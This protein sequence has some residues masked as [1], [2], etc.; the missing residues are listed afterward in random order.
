MHLSC[1]SIYKD[2]LMDFVSVITSLAL[3]QTCGQSDASSFKFWQAMHPSRKM[4]STRLSSEFLKPAALR[5]KANLSDPTNSTASSINFAQTLSTCLA[6]S[7]SGSQCSFHSSSMAP[8]LTLLL[9]YLQLFFKWSLLPASQ[10]QT[11]LH[12][13]F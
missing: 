7:H 4:A 6:L 11:P 9:T 13:P 1:C 5:S 10:L 12:T 2:L 3:L 8:C